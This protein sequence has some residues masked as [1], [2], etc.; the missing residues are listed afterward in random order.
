MW[1]E[2]SAILLCSIR[3]KACIYYRLLL[4]KR[5][6]V[7][8]PNICSK[9]YTTEGANPTQEGCGHIWRML[10]PGQLGKL[11]CLT[12]GQTHSS[13]SVLHDTFICF[14]TCEIEMKFSIR[15]KNFQTLQLFLWSLSTQGKGQWLWATTRTGYDQL[16]GVQR[17]SCHHSSVAPAVLKK[18]SSYF[19]TERYQYLCSKSLTKYMKQER[20]SIKHV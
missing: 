15:M 19:S 7:E 9:T 12:E 6:V 1:V 16:G 18:K 17:P 13:N 3:L 11:W 10:I 2:I 20:L 14:Y 5:T 8:H 4:G